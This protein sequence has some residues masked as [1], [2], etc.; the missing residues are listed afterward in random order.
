MD[1][2]FNVLEVARQHGIN[3]IFWP[4]SIAVFGRGAPREKTPQDAP[5]YP[6]TMYGNTKVAGELLCSYYSSRFGMDVRCL[7]F[8]GIISSE[9]PPT[10][11]TTDYNVAMF[12]DAVREGKYACFVREDTI[13]PM[14][15]M[16][17][18]VK[19]ITDVMEASEESMKWRYGYNVTSMSPS[20]GELAAEIKKFIPGFE[21]T[22]VPD[23]RQEIADS[24]PMSLD[25]GEARRDWGW[26]PSYDLASMTRDMIAKVSEKFSKRLPSRTA[27]S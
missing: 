11:G 26:R 21:C 8:P 25:D 19:S 6:T 14:M 13:L 12:Y 4:S 5:L 17:D 23:F 10:G 18:C 16:P 27:L 9:T 1:G 20:A 3:R 2:L 15:Y 7:R 24:W 22:Y